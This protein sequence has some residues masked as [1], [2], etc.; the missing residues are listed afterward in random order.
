MANR[1]KASSILRMMP[2]RLVPEAA[3]RSP[4]LV[5][6]VKSSRGMMPSA[7]AIQTT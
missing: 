3:T 1:A 6:C 5:M 4:T 7:A 2:P